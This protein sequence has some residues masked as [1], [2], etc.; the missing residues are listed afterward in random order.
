MGS[1]GRNFEFRIVPQ[2]EN[3][4]GRFA[5]PATG[6]KIPIGAPI[7]TNAAGGVDSGGKQRVQLAA[8]GAAPDKGA[9]GIAVF[10]YG[11]AAYAGNDIALTTYSDMDTVPLDA[12]VQMVSGPN[13]KVVLRNTVEQTFLTQRNYTARRMVAGL[14]ADQ[15]VTPSTVAVGDTLVPGPGT[16][17]GGYWAVTGAGEAGWLRVTK[18][19]DARGELEAHFTF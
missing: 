3:R 13:V 1:Y 10:E 8:A 9:A 15:G 19:D 6:T 17:A 4:P 18:V 14:T 16:D 7:V 11:P 2:S 5:T 12:G